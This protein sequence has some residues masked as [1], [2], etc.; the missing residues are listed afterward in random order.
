MCVD[1]IENYM[2]RDDYET[3]PYTSYKDGCRAFI[4]LVDFLERFVPANQFLI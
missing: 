3:I 1:I 2:L 4:R